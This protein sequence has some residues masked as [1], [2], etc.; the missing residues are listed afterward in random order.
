MN[1]RIR[2]F[3][4]LL[5]AFALLSFVSSCGRTEKENT[6]KTI[7][8]GVVVYRKDDTFISS[9]CT[10][11]EECAKKKE[12]ETGNKINLNI[13]ESQSSQTIQNDQVDGF[14]SRD[15]RVICVNMVDRTAAA[16]IVDKAKKADVPVVFFNREPVDEDIRMWEKAYYVGADAAVSG[17]IQGQIIA[18]A[19]RADPRSI[20][21]N[22]DGVIQYVM[23]EGEQGHQ[24]AL[25]RTEYSVK[26]LVDAGLRVEKLANDTANWQRAQGTAKMTQ[27]IA[28]YGSRIEVVLSNNDDMA[29]GA[30]DAIKES[31]LKAHPPVVVGV[32]AT[33]PGL[34]AIKNGTML[35][36][37]FNDAQKQA[38]A[39]FNLSYSF[40]TGGGVPS[41]VKLTQQH[42]VYI[43]YKM[44]T[45]ANLADVKE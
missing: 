33:Q 13:M 5:T 24:D 26:A 9:L 45:K 23:L 14:L 39:I 8:I 37:A 7:S 42:Y 6:V 38:E 12:N 29:L 18:N 35:G 10:Y 44:V 19:Y 15:Y 28:K 32:D 27:W 43:P 21:K 16:V 22:G 1:R 34:D 17:S 11:L 36:T 41:S 40:A 20:D 31:P 4:L 30:I 3:A 25:L 2:F